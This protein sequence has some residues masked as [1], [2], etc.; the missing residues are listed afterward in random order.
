M[1]IE[2]LFIQGCPNHAPALSRLREAM[3]VENVSAAIKEIEIQDEQQALALRFPGSPTVRVN[4][5]D[6]ESEVRG[7]EASFAC[8]VY[9]T[10]EGVFAGLPPLEM[11]REAIRVGTRR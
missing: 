8:R 2:L 3:K 5:K 11:I 10:T 1:K 7:D 9:R 6:I 4:G